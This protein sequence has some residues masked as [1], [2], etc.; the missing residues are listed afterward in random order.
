[1]NPLR[2]ELAQFTGSAQWFRHSFN[3]AVIYTEGIQY[4]AENGGA[5][6]LIDAI[7]SHLASDEFRKAARK[8]DRISLMHFWKL[9][10]KPDHS[11]LLTAIP[12]TGE[13]EFI[14][15][16]IPFTDFPPSVP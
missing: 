10:V 9:A 11:A 4:L 15:Q 5:Y 1:M 16:A 14:Q 6:W 13:P 8:D 12:D 2:T 3:R 7:A